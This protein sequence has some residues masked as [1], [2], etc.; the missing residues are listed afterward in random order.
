VRNGV[1]THYIT[2]FEMSDL[3]FSL[4]FLFSILVIVKIIRKNVHTFFSKTVF[5]NISLYWI[6]GLYCRMSVLVSLSIVK[7]CEII[8]AHSWQHT[9]YSS[10]AWF[11]KCGCFNPAHLDKSTSGT[12]IICP[13]QV[14]RT[15]R[16]TLFK[17]F[18][19]LSFINSFR[20]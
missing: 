15:T 18:F 7:N 16:Y 4:P 9:E 3:L 1:V 20:I 19:F 13:I 8:E 17:H 5:Y 14:P 11:L 2:K 6:P 12:A 10:I